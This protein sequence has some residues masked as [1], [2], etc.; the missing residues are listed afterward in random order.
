MSSATREASASSHASEVFERSL[1]PMEWRLGNAE[2]DAGVK[3]GD[4]LG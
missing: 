4:L 1:K 2:G 3:N